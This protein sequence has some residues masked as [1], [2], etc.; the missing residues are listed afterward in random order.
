VFSF[1]PEQGLQDAVIP[2]IMEAHE[3]FWNAWVKW[4]GRHSIQNTGYFKVYLDIV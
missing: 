1:L 2:M 4:K 3:Y